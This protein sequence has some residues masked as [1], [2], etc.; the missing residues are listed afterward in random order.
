M[1]EE[2]DVDFGLIRW[3]PLTIPYHRMKLFRHLRQKYLAVSAGS[4]KHYQKHYDHCPHC[5]EKTPWMAR[6]LSG[7]YRCLQCGNDPL[8]AE[9]EQEPGVSP[10]SDAPP[11]ASDAASETGGAERAHR[12]SA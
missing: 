8:V 9:R 11:V 10:R 5:E 1:P 7:Y 4:S 3:F 2:S 12:R 6:V